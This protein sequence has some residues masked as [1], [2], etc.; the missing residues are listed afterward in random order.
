[1][2]LAFLYSYKSDLILLSEVAS[3]GNPG[4]SVQMIDEDD[5]GGFSRFP[6][7][8]RRILRNTGRLLVSETNSDSPLSSVPPLAPATMDI[9]NAQN[10]TVRQRHVRPGPTTYSRRDRSGRALGAGTGR[11]E[12][13]ATLEAV[14]VLLEEIA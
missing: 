8:P 12:N 13:E 4:S 6:A 2:T 9:T 5:I 7:I 14:C 1:M 10:N 11:V 3:P